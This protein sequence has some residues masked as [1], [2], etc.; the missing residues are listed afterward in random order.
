MFLMF[1]AHAAEYPREWNVFRAMEHVR[2]ALTRSHISQV[3]IR[4]LLLILFSSAP[5]HSCSVK[6][7]QTQYAFNWRVER[8][9]PFSFISSQRRSQMVWEGT[10]SLQGMQSPFQ[11]DSL[12]QTK[13]IQKLNFKFEH[14]REIVKSESI[15]NYSKW[16]ISSNGRLTR[17]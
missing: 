10:M 7:E 8:T 15:G 3:S 17:W 16:H 13:L 6:S 14:R 9:S 2:S 5:Q 11:A 1:C 12:V 4:R